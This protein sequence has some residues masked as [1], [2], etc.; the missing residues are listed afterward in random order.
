MKSSQ[1]F[2][3]LEIM[4][5]VAIVGILAAIAYPNYQNY[6]IRTK[7][8]AMMTELQ[9]IGRQIEARKLAIGRGGYSKISTSGLTGNYPK[10]GIAVYTVAINNLNQGNWELQATP[11]AGGQMANDGVLKLRFDGWKC[12]GTDTTK[13]GMG[14]QWRD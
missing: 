4:V 13:C 1:G 6:V 10:Q 3:L 14:N 11:I 12:R 7:R 9:D 2:T 5:V 8:A